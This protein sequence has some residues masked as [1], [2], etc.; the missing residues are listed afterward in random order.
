MSVIHVVCETATK[1]GNRQDC[2]TTDG[3]VQLP[4]K[5][6]LETDDAVGKQWSLTGVCM[7]VFVCVR[8]RV[9]GLK[10]DW[11]AKTY[12]CGWVGAAAKRVETVLSYTAWDFNLLLMFFLSGTKLFAQSP[13]SYKC[14]LLNKAIVIQSTAHNCISLTGREVR[15]HW[16]HRSNR[17]SDKFCSFAF[18]KWLTSHCPV[19]NVSNVIWVGVPLPKGVFTSYD[20]LAG[21]VNT[22]HRCCY[23]YCDTCLYV[24]DRFCLCAMI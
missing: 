3:Q 8:V 4:G 14:S 2:R 24:S 1:R 10:K 5:I 15:R 20:R 19:P 21:I 7:C 16:N 22:N 13:Q 9:T 23:T 12:V 6:L 17:V 18:C 11:K